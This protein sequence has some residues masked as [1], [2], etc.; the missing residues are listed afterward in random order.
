[1]CIRDSASLVRGILRRTIVPNEQI[2]VREVVR[3][4]HHL[5][6]EARYQFG[7]GLFAT[8]MPGFGPGRVRIPASSD[9]PW[10]KNGKY[11]YCYRFSNS[12]F[13]PSEIDLD[14]RCPTAKELQAFIS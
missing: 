2:S 12:D 14:V 1:M 11:E 4:G 10:A 8:D 7:S 5:K 13:M 3:T 9:G 6:C